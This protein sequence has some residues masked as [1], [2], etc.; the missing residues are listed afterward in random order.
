MKHSTVHWATLPLTSKKEL[1]VSSFLLR[2][3]DLE[4]K[5]QTSALE[6]CQLGFNIIQCLLF[7]KKYPK[8]HDLKQKLNLPVWFRPAIPTLKEMETGGLKV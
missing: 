1:H 3:L 4:D 7:C 2:K 5:V 8:S 6:P